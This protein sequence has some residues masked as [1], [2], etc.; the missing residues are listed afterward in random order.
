[1]YRGFSTRRRPRGP[2]PSEL[3]I[4]IAAND[5]VSTLKSVNVDACFM[6]SMA[7][8]LFGNTRKPNVRILK[9]ESNQLT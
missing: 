3:Q 4:I 7:C 9:R 5:V 8:K 6:G 2:P 1:M